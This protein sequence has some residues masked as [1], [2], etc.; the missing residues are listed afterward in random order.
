MSRNFV[1][2][3]A[4]EGCSH[5]GVCG[6]D[7]GHNIVVKPP[8]IPKFEGH[9]KPNQ[10]KEQKIRM[11]FG[12]IDEMGLISHL[13]LVRLFDRAIRRA[14]LPISFTGGYHPGPKIAI[15]NALSLGITSNGEIVDFE[16]SDDM[17]VEEFRTRLAAQL[18]EN[19]PIYKVE[20]IDL[21]SPNAS[22]LMDKAEYLITVQ[23]EDNPN[24]QQWTDSINNSQEIL[25]EKFTK[26]G[27]KQ[28]INLRDRLFAFNLESEEN[29][30]AVIRFTG[31]CRNDGTNLS[32]DNLVYMLEQ[33]SRVE[34]QLLNVHRQQL[35]L[36]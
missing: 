31:S 1:P 5:C 7:F 13:D 16:L 3:C 19:I 14:A 25:R 18:P 29:N 21:K 4:F 23:V 26:S 33:I 12:K 27:N 10:D 9:F 28:V 15:A 20:D 30:T 8:E 22:R 24:W 11:W 36:N 2:D 17:D 32:P 35:I 34:V 6:T